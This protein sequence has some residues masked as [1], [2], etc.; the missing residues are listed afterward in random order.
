[1]ACHILSEEAEPNKTGEA[2]NAAPV[3]AAFFMKI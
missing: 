3:V 2:I 1:M